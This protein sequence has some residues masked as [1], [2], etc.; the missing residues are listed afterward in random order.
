MYSVGRFIESHQR[1]LLKWHFFSGTRV[2][3]CFR[4]LLI[5]VVSVATMAKVLKYEMFKYLYIRELQHTMFLTN[6]KTRRLFQMW[7]KHHWIAL[8]NG[9][10]TSGEILYCETR[11]TRSPGAKV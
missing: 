6:P 5:L 3:S 4:C 7:C 9:C 2:Y 8:K 1:M 10:L 11:S